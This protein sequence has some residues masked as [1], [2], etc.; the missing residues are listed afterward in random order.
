M[1]LRVKYVDKIYKYSI[2][3]TNLT[4]N[5]YFYGIQMYGNSPRIYRTLVLV[6]S[7][8]TDGL[9]QDLLGRCVIYGITFQ[10]ADLEKMVS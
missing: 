3:K 6:D 7:A 9:W 4:I 10:P 8:C 2:L 5:F 1:F